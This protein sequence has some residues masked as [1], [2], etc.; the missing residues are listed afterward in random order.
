VPDIRTSSAATSSTAAPPSAIGSI[1][2]IARPFFPDGQNGRYNGPLS[3]PFEIWSPFQT[4]LQLDL[5]TR[6]LFAHVGFVTS[7]S[8]DTA[9]RCANLA[10]LANGLQIFPGG[11]PLYR[12]NTLVGWIGVSGDGIDQ[13]DMVAFLG[14]DRRA[15]AAHRVGNAPSSIRADRLDPTGST[16][17]TSSAR[18]AVSEF[19]PAERLR[20]L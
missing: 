9:P 17:A 11:L 5:I 16:S 14:A 7:G 20:G 12:G 8:R 4:G 18:S 6:N 15:G 1:G 3:L 2:N 13:D 10:R 19:R